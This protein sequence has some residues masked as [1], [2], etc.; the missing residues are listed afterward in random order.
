MPRGFWIQ[1][2]E[3]TREIIDSGC[4][5]KNRSPRVAGSNKGTQITG[6][7]SGKGYQTLGLGSMKSSQTT[8][9]RSKKGSQTTDPGSVKGTQITGSPKGSENT[10][11][12]LSPT[13][14]PEGLQNYGS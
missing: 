5:L 9:P 7:G 3:Y 12:K 11:P 1:C 8:V 13:T 2:Y 10:G 6:H 14:D 4:C